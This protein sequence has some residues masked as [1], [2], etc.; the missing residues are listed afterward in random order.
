MARALRLDHDQPPGLWQPPLRAAAFS[1]QFVAGRP[2]SL[3]LCSGCSLTGRSDNLV[4]DQRKAWRLVRGRRPGRIH[5]LF[6]LVEAYLQFAPP[7]DLRPFLGEDGGL[8]GGYRHDPIYGVSYRNAEAFRA[9]NT[10]RLA[11]TA[12]MF[13]GDHPTPVWAFFGNSFVQASG[14]LADAARSRVENR[15]VFNR[16]GRPH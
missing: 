12:P 16:G 10:A 15:D 5:D 9:E 6:L 1:P 14:M 13:D 3:V 7:E 11:D 8:S 2:W 4:N